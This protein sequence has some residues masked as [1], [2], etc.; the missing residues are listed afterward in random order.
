MN[1][2]ISFYVL[3]YLIL[4]SVNINAQQDGSSCSLAI[5]VNP[6]TYNVTELVG[7]SSQPNVQGSIWYSF[8]PTSSGLLSINS[9]GGGAD[10]K[11]WIWDVC[12]SDF[13]TIQAVSQ[14]DDT[15]GCSSLA[16]AT[17]NY[18]SSISNLVL[19]AGNTYFFEWDGSPRMVCVLH[20]R[21]FLMQYGQLFYNRV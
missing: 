12:V 3:L 5:P 19:I 4:L 15:P 9:C 18:A 6:G 20:W 13:S 8:T 7:V 16:N 10:T 21:V 1:I 14:N 2:K 17:N 11:L